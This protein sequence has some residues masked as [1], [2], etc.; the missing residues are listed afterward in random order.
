MSHIASPL[1]AWVFDNIIKVNFPDKALLNHFT[2]SFCDVA[3]VRSIPYPPPPLH[4]STNVSLWTLHDTV[5]KNKMLRSI[6]QTDP[7]VPL[8]ITIHVVL[9]AGICT[10]CEQAVLKQTHQNTFFFH[11]PLVYI[12]S[13]QSVTS[14]KT[15]RAK[16][17]IDCCTSV[18]IFFICFPATN[19]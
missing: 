10:K 3:A 1:T 2:H 17:S 9:N 19:I 13:F 14:S 12:D 6:P 11:S 15:W 5:Y 18:S 7:G 4:L 16:A 8:K